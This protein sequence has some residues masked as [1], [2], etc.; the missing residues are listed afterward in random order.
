MFN[1]TEGVLHNLLLYLRNALSSR[2]VLTIR[3]FIYDLWRP[4]RKEGRKLVTRTLLGL[5]RIIES[6]TIK[7]RPFKLRTTSSTSNVQP[8][9]Y[10]SKT[11]PSTTLTFQLDPSTILLQM[12]KLEE[13]SDAT[14]RSSLP[15]RL[16][17]LVEML[18][19]QGLGEFVQ[20]LYNVLRVRFADRCRFQ[21]AADIR[22]RQ[23]H[24]WVLWFAW[25]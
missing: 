4:T 6:R 19:K 22:G 12:P 8:A 23:R 13:E 9:W 2:G 3:L 24:P 11:S 18:L 16:G 17:T 1:I 21:S 14:R 10:A 20:H 25:T 5:T 15:T 7:F